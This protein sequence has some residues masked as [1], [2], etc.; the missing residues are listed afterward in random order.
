M[1]VDASG[2][3]NVKIISDGTTTGTKVTLLDGTPIKGI[4]AVR[5]THNAGEMAKIELD[6]VPYSVEVEAQLGLINVQKITK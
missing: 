5:L 2:M 1:P 6:I 4:T 3:L